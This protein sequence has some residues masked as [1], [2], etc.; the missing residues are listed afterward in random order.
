MNA[1]PTEENPFPARKFYRCFSKVL[2]L[3]GMQKTEESGEAPTESGVQ[4]ETA[5][6][7]KAA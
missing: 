2:E 1:L 7:T 4:S 6:E 5:T 3:K